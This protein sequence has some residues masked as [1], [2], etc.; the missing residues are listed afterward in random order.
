[1]VPVFRAWYTKIMEVE[2]FLQVESFAG[3]P[4]FQAGVV[5]DVLRATSTMAQALALGADAVRIFRDVDPLKTAFARWPAE[6]PLLLGERDGITLP[7][8]D[9][10]NS[11]LELSAAELRGRTVFMTTTNGTRAASALRDVAL[12]FAAALVNRMAVARL[13]AGRRPERVAIVASGWKGAFALEDVL[14]AGALLAGLRDLGVE[15]RLGSD[16]AVAAEALFL[17]CLP[18]MGSVME[19]TW[20]AR[21]LRAL[22]AAGDVA[23]CS[24]LDV[25]DVAPMRIAP[26]CFASGQE[27]AVEEAGRP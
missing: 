26:D 5:V 22:G 20:S 12:V 25:L 4:G 21:R 24:R 23:W 13:L 11:P 1:M 15:I 17:H 27:K 8:F 10:G 2:V 14:G 18:R 3:E 7:D 6:R 16:A 9:R 19:E